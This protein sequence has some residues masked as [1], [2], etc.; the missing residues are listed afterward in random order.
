MNPISTNRSASSKTKCVSFDK[1]IFLCCKWSRSLP[2]VLT[3]ISDRAISFIW[4]RNDTP[5]YTVA[6][7]KLL[8]FPNFP[9]SLEIWTASSLVGARIKAW[10]PFFG[11][12]L[13]I[14]GIPKAAVFPDP[15]LDFPIISFPELISGIDFSWIS[16]GSVI[17]N[18]ER[19]R[20]MFEFTPNSLNVF[21]CIC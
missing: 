12:T 15:V 3:T 18:S 2:G 1:S 16:V 8:Y 6:I 11:T 13:L 4:G 21:F 20:T 9:S 7:P 19:A 5:P 17:P 10:T 14:N